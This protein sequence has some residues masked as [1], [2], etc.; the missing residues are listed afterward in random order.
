MYKRRERTSFNFVFD[1]F[2]P[3]QIDRRV[4]S[5]LCVTAAAAKALTESYVVH[6]PRASARLDERTD[7]RVCHCLLSLCSISLRARHGIQRRR[8]RLSKKAFWKRKEKKVNHCETSSPNIPLAATCLQ[9]TPLSFKVETSMLSNGNDIIGCPRCSISVSVSQPLSEC[10]NCAAQAAR[11]LPPPT[12]AWSPSTVASDN[13]DYEH[14]SYDY[15]YADPPPAYD[16]FTVPRYLEAQM[17]GP[18]PR[19][20]IS[21]LDLRATTNLD[22][23]EGRRPNGGGSRSLRS[24]AGGGGDHAAFRH[25]G[26]HSIEAGT[27]VS[28]GG[29]HGGT[30]TDVR[31]LGTTTTTPLLQLRPFTRRPAAATAAWEQARTLARACGLLVALVF[32][33]FMI[34]GL[35]LMVEQGLHQS[36]V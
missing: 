5:F 4:S 20:A 26:E 33:A 8:R 14:G 30:D 11:A 31:P 12:S 32:I 24:G 29:E 22:P 21:V 7:K 23:G 17:P 27:R 28:G 25:G 16:T 15:E 36:T 9:Q 2:P 6:V 19:R 10:F 3:R 34:H 18:P 35:A 1:C 13:D